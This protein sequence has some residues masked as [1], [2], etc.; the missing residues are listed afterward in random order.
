LEPLPIHD[1]FRNATEQLAGVSQD[2]K[3]KGLD[4]L[5][6]L[7]EPDPVKRMTAEGALSHP[8]LTDDFHSTPLDD[9]PVLINEKH[10]TPETPET[11]LERKILELFMDDAADSNDDEDDDGVDDDDDDDDDDDEIFT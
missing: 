7:L 2:F 6:S 4:F 5:Q 3:R 9:M 11:T 1:K 8:F 10:N